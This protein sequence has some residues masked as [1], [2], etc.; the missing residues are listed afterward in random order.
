MTPV[1]AL[2]LFAVSWPLLLAIYVV[3]ANR[4]GCQPRTALLKST[5][6]TR[7]TTKEAPT[8][9][10]DELKAHPR[11][12]A[13]AET[14]SSPAVS[15]LIVALTVNSSLETFIED[16][17]EETCSWGHRTCS[18]CQRLRHEAV[19]FNLC[20]MGIRTLC[21]NAAARTEFEGR[22]ARRSEVSGR[23]RRYLIL[24]PRVVNLHSHAELVRVSTRAILGVTPSSAARMHG[25]CDLRFYSHFERGCDIDFERR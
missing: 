7:T 16:S 18:N 5:S 14:P 3:G 20:C 19:S 11:V 15:M 12:N 10:V 6:K 22:S 4:S 23:R 8:D 2:R 21:S 25:A 9:Q 1:S 24:G 13:A 17:N